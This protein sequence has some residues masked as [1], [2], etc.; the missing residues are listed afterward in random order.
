MKKLKS[1]INS[2]SVFYHSIKSL[3]SSSLPSEDMKIKIYKT[4][5]LAVVLYGCETLCLTLREKHRVRT[6]ENGVLRRI[7]MYEAGEDCIMRSFIT[8]TLHQVLLGL[9]NQ[10]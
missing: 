1:R 5:I 2:E 9:S 10:G 3:L 4:I 7:Y 8:C 6:F